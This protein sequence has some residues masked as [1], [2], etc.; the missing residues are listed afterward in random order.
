[1]RVHSVTVCPDRVDVLVEM[2]DSEPV[3]TRP[4]DAVGSRVL[5]LLPELGRH[6]C[7]NGS[8]REFAD[9]LDDTEVP[10][11]F[12]HVVLELMA[13][14][15]SPR[16]LRGETEWDFKRDG[17]GVFRVSVEYDDDLVCLGAIKAADKVMAYLLADGARPDVDAEAAKILG[18]RGVPVEQ[19]C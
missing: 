3:R 8:G 4:E 12:E 18:L 17:R 7:E 1:M 10:H 9:E 13:R 11:L 15:G 6:R 5:A 2:G 14:S 19:A 16:T